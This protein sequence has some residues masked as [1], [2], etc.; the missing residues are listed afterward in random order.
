MAGLVSTSSFLLL[1]ALILDEAFLSSKWVFFTLKNR[2]QKS[3]S[4]TQGLVISFFCLNVENYNPSMICKFLH[5]NHPLLLY[6]LTP[7]FI[8]QSS[9]GEPTCSFFKPTECVHPYRSLQ[10][11]LLLDIRMYFALTSHKWLFLWVL[12]N[13]FIPLSCFK[14]FHLYFHNSS[15]LPLPFTGKTQEGSQELCGIQRGPPFHHWQEERWLSHGPH[16]SLH[17]SLI[18]LPLPSCLSPSGIILQTS[19]PRTVSYCSVSDS[20]HQKA[21]WAMR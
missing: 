3:L 15:C 20:N 21:L 17:P 5:G 2:Y 7:L 13:Y 8:L 9:Q 12:P 18:I 11:L 16:V 6:P 1:S 19:K 10:V 4:E 14:H